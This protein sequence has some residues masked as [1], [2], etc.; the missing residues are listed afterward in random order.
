MTA[1]W[2]IT[3]VGV[4][5][6]T[7]IIPV[8]WAIVGGSAAFTLGV[9]A[10]LALILAAVVVALDALAPTALGERRHTAAELYAR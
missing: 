3:S 8:T 5:R 7:T 10:D 9:R 4:P 2:L 1:G 6:V